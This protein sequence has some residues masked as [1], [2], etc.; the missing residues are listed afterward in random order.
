MRIPRQYN[1]SN[2]E[3]KA[4]SI[5][6]AGLIEI[7]FEESFPNGFEPPYDTLTLPW[8]NCQIPYRDEALVPEEFTPYLNKFRN[9][10]D[11]YDE[12][13]PSVSE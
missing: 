3:I 6:Y 12:L 2:I 13:F 10:W 4:L 5:N 11:L 8:G 9:L 7:Q 1:G